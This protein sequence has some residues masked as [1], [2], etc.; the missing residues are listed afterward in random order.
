VAVAPLLPAS[1]PLFQNQ[2]TATLKVKAEMKVISRHIPVSIRDNVHVRDERQC[3]YIGS[4]GH[5]CEERSG[6]QLDHVRPFSQG[7]EHT[8]DNVT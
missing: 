5:R 4:D 3:T 7:G 8:E 1:G 6:L 2:V